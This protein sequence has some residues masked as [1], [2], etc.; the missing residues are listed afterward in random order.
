MD[1]PATRT[2]GQ[3]VE[4][5]DGNNVVCTGAI[6]TATGCHRLTSATSRT[7]GD[8]TATSTVADALTYS[9]E[10][11]DAGSFSIDRAEGQISTKALLNYEKKDTYKVRVRATDP[12]GGTH[13]A[14]TDSSGATRTHTIDVTINVTPVPEDPEITGGATTIRVDENTATTTILST[15]TATDD[16]DDKAKEALSWS[17][18]G[19]SAGIFS[20]EG[21]QLKFRNSPNFEGLA[22]SDV[23]RTVTVTVTDSVGTTDTRD[24]EVTVIDVDETGSIQAVIVVNN[25]ESEVQQP[26]SGTEI[27][28]K[29]TDPDD[30]IE[31]TD[32]TAEL[33]WQWA[34]STS[35]NGPWNDIDTVSAKTATY[36]PRDSDVGSYLRVTATYVD[37]TTEDDTTTPDVDEREDEVHKVFSATVLPSTQN[38]PPAFPVQ[39][40]A[41]G[42]DRT[43]Q[44]RRV[45]ENAKVNDLVGAP[46]VATDIRPDGRQDRLVYSLLDDDDDTNVPNR[47]GPDNDD[48]E[49]FK[50]NSATGQISV[51]KEGLDYEA[52]NPADAET[53]PGDKTYNVLV[54]A[55]DTSNAST[56][57]K[58]EI[59]VID[60][61]EA[62]KRADEIDSTTVQNLS[63]TKTVEHD[64]DSTD[65][66]ATTT[67][68]STYAATDDEDDNATPAVMREWSLEG[69]DEDM[70]VLCEEDDDSA[71]CSDPNDPDTADR[72]NIVSLRFKENPDFEARAD[73]GGNNVYNV[74]VVATD[75]D[76]QTASRNVAV[77]LSNVEENG[78]VTLS[79][80]QPEVGIP[81]TASLADPDG[82]VQ[83]TTWKWYRAAS[84][85]SGACVPWESTDVVEEIPNATS[86]TYTPVAADADTVSTGR[87]LYPVATYTDNHRPP[88]QPDTTE[89]ESQ[90]K[91][92]ATGT[93]AFVVQRMDSNNQVPVFPNQN[94][95]VTIRISEST[96]EG[97]PLGGTSPVLVEAQDDDDNLTYTLS[98]AD[99]GFFTI[100]TTDDGGQIRVGKGTKLD[101]D[102]GRRS[103]TVTVTATDPSLASASVTVTIEIVNEN[104]APEVSTKGLV[105]S[106]AASVSYAEDRDDAVETYTAR[107]DEAAGASWSLSG[108]DASAFSIPGG[109]LSFNSQPDFE[110]PADAGTDNVY[111][112]TVRASGGTISASRDVAVTVTNVD[113][114]GTATITSSGQPRVGVELTASLTDIDGTPT[115]ISWQWSRS[116]SN[117]G[118]W[119]NIAG[120]RQANYTPTV[121]DENNYLRATASYTDPHGPSKSKS[122]VTSATVL[123]ASTEGTPGTVALTPSTQLTS[124]DSVTATLTDADNP[125]NH[126][127][128]WAR[129]STASGTFTNIPN[130]T[131]ASYTTTD[132]DAGN[133]LR[134]TVTYDDDSGTGKT[135]DAPTSSA[136]KLH[137]YDGNANGEIERTEVI[138]AINAYLFGTGTNRDEVIEVINLYLFG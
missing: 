52:T 62:P 123:A 7:E 10:G 116:T 83:S 65:N 126:A 15:Y 109:V 131:S 30:E 61:R 46:V 108:D 73:S 74:M 103:Y 38:K 107:G 50:I 51:K 122:A 63:A 47:D 54:K 80:R 37:G 72:N 128:R 21:G 19:A 34:T 98:G 86:R 133:Y 93:S 137:R 25:V 29:L 79:N 105:V 85:T 27:T 127:W 20:I 41:T 82:G 4:A 70:F 71:T 26:R 57:V 53:D 110:A 114:D 115:A 22:N 96:A 120:G 94:A 13:T 121:A 31:V 32:T 66:T 111:N 68:L 40:D 101:Y 36:T 88:D 75:N 58:V 56:T 12:T 9:L 100:D 5:T 24:V 11:T 132:D 91:D 2:I 33:T 23:T 67:V 113:E 97:A 118:G 117:T 84:A 6:S 64:S 42:D 102:Q 35:A 3:P 129:S 95:A 112:V 136:V 134:A 16:E 18:T 77:T 44:E 90:K 124:G 99:A 14:R 60:V 81:I 119:S 104:E 69:V 43:A 8:L 1:N 48:D 106:G 135:A 59:K 39:D 89:D 138:D 130:A 92:M 76:G 49:F 87:C 78:E 17:L 28:A 55:V 45:S 125:V